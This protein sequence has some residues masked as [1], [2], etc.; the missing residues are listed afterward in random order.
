[1]QHPGLARGTRRAA[2]LARPRGLGS[3]HPPHARA[4]RRPRAH[5]ASTHRPRRAARVV[6]SVEHGL[7]VEAGSEGWFAFPEH[8]A[9]AVRFE[10]VEPQRYLAWRWVPGD[11]DVPIAEAAEVTLVEW[12]LSSRAD[13]GTTLHLVESGFRGPQKF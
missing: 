4:R 3:P 7:R 10:T 6:G 12:V 2:R 1:R 8:G 11:R 13:G 5:L 9:H